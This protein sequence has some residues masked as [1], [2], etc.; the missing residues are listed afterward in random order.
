VVVETMLNHERVPRPEVDQVAGHSAERRSVA[1]GVRGLARVPGEDHVGQPPV[2]GLSSL[3]RGQGHRRCIPVDRVE[4]V[5][6]F[7]VPAV[8]LAECASGPPAEVRDHGPC[9]DVRP[10]VLR[11]PMRHAG[12]E[13]GIEVR[14]VAVD[15]EAGDAGLLGDGGD[16]GVGWPDRRV[17]ANG[18]LSDAQPGLV[19]LLGAPPHAVRARFR[20]TPLLMQC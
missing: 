6:V 5:G 14:E 8:K 12:H 2:P 20:R 13:H 10:G 15:G 3:L 18:C 11:G 19:H 4:L 17:Q 1:I 16:R 9:R 7:P